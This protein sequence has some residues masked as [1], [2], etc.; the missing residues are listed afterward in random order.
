[1]TNYEKIMSDISLDKMAHL[2]KDSSCWHC[3]YNRN[4][5][6]GYD[7]LNG[8][9]KWLKKQSKEGRKLEDIK[10]DDND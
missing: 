10:D 4:K 5:F 1:M 8:I 6:C 9:K 2:I 7:C 3:V